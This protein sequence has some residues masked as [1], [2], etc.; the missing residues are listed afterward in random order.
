MKI[1]K[2]VELLSTQLKNS[3]QEVEFLKRKYKLM[4]NKAVDNFKEKVIYAFCE[5][6]EEFGNEGFS[7]K[8]SNL[9]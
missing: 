9:G 2:T 6:L 3:Q 8:T 1:E 7:A 4:W 5:I